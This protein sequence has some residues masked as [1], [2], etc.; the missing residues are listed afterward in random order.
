MSSSVSKYYEDLEDEAHWAKQAQLKKK[1]KFKTFLNYI[2][3][4][5]INS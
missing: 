1:S 2:F 4:I 5:K 3:N